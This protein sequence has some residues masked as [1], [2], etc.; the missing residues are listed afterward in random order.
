VV[1]D[2]DWQIACLAFTPSADYDTFVLQAGLS[3]DITS[4]LAADSQLF[5]DRLRSAEGCGF[6]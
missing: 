6:Q 5:F 3:G 1:P 4:V 2:G